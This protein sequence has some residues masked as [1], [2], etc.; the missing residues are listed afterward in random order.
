[1]SIQIDE[2]FRS[3]SSY[4]ALTFLTSF[5]RNGQGHEAED[6]LSD[7]ISVTP[8]YTQQPQKL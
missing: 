7:F 4:M 8:V 1:M 3:T 5:L 2:S 6:I